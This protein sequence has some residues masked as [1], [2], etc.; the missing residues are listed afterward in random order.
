M[1]ELRAALLDHLYSGQLFFSAATLFLAIIVF[2][3][4][5][6]LDTRPLARRIAGVLA[7]LAIPLGGMSGTPLPLVVA[8]AAILATLAYAFAGLGGRPAARR[9][10]GALAAMAVLTAIFTELPYHRIRPLRHRALH[11]SV[12]GDS[13]ASGGFG[14]QRPWPEILG[15]ELGI[16]VTNLALPSDGATTALP[17]QVS[18]LSM[19]SADQTVIVEIGGND[20]LEGTPAKEF[21]ASLDQ[22]LT[23]A[24]AGRRQVLVLELPLLPGRWQYGAIQRRVA[25]K[26]NATLVPKRILARVLLDEE[27]TFDGLHLTQQG[28][29]A[30]A[31]NLLPFFTRSSWRTRRAR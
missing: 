9:L 31:R 21:A 30:L 24:G 16:P 18:R 10:L 8:A 7:L 5:G 15:R 13:L 19:P 1:N 29:D 6:W 27:N 22:I 12:I 2:D 28:H 3:V 14:E 26:H 25:A 17:N 20:M 4:S 11:L 23:R